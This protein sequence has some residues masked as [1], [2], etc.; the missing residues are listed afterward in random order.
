[1]SQKR[2]THFSYSQL[3]RKK[4]SLLV[5]T[6]SLAAL[7]WG[8]NND[9]ANATSKDTFVD[10]SELPALMP[11]VN[12]TS[13]VGLEIPASQIGLATSGA[14]ISS[15]ELIAAKSE[16]VTSNSV[17]HATP[18]YCKILGDIYPVDGTAPNIK[19]Q[20]NIPTSWNQKTIQVGGGNL[21]GA[22]P[23]NLDVISNSGSP[24]SAAFP[25]DATYPISNGY[26]SYAGDSGHQYSNKSNPTAAETEWALN[27]EAWLNFGHAG[28]KKTH[29][30]AFAIIKKL[31][32]SRPAVSYFMGQSQGGREAMEAAQRYPNDY[33]G[34]VA[35][36]PVMGYSAH[37]I[38][39]TLLATIQTGAGWIPTAKLATIGN[40]VTRQCD[41][42]DGIE[43]GVI[44]NYLACNALF[45]PQKVAA[46]FNNIRCTDGGDTNVNCLSDA[47]I[48]TINQMHS[49]TNYGFDLAN[50]LSSFSGYGT[51]R[52]SLSGWLNINPQPSQSE[53]PE[54][55][56]PGLTLRYG[57]LKD[58][59]FNLVN[60]KIEDHKDKIQAASTLIDAT[61][62]DLTEFF[63]RGGRIIIKNNSSDYSANPQTVMHYYNTLVSKFGQD[64]VDAHVRYYILPNANHSGAGASNITGTAIPQY[65]NLVE[66]ATNWV[67]KN[68]LP[69]DAPVV[70]AKEMLPPYTI[71]ASKP[72]CRYPLYPHYKGEGD[73][74]RASSYEC[75]SN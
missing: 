41:T 57:I 1:M 30:V 51:G 21:N 13:L 19:F 42:L 7:L 58:P 49:V 53:Q 59:T 74:S 2:S 72:M 36:A 31:Y 40:E 10:T 55:G 63:A 62:P 23:S 4:K 25:P 26:A 60:F 20:L 9:D 6:T 22:I 8:C 18:E 47:Q 16:T 14:K 65:V 37:V 5:L 48:A 70:T 64:T 61:N 32:G 38:A 45:D 43:D 29:D 39:K 75:I 56:S 66:M 44:S 27:N 15:A 50:G 54:L 24:I 11:K 3:V 71:S 73:P 67:E 34:I 17:I 35:T 46:P 52:E 69:P 12:C 28:I 33:N 68:T